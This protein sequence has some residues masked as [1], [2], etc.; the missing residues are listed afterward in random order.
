MH[1]HRPPARRRLRAA[2]A[3]GA[4]LTAA[5]PAVAHADSIAY[6]KGGDV[7]LS[8]SDGARQHQ[9]TTGGG[10]SSVSQDDRGDMI[11]AYGTRLRWLG[12]D[13]SVRADFHTP[14]STGPGAQ[15]GADGRQWFGPF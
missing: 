13:G 9:V 5:A 12:R 7:W 10:Y 8:T 15:D 2:L 14:V 3:A 11:A 4:L 1:A 6:V